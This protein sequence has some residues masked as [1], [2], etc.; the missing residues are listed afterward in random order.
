[1]LLECVCFSHCCTDCSHRCHRL[2]EYTPQ[3]VYVHCIVAVPTGLEWIKIKLIIRKVTAA[4]LPL[5]SKLKFEVFSVR[6]PTPT[7]VGR[8]IVQKSHASNVQFTSA[9]E[10]AAQPI[11]Q[12]ARFKWNHKHQDVGIIQQ[13]SQFCCESQSNQSENGSRV[14]EWLRG[15]IIENAINLRRLM[16][17]L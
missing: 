15:A 1:M 12:D 3:R 16:I 7:L 14:P 4:G 5:P 10:Q 2:S 13:S 9:L 6:S 8:L 17:I 11:N